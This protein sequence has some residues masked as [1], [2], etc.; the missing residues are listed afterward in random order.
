MTASTPRQPLLDVDHARVVFPQGGPHG[1]VVAVDDVSLTL[2]TGR[3]M[4]LVGASGCGKSS[5]AR[6]IMHLIPL[7]SGTI[8]IMGEDLSRL[9]RD[10]RRRKRRHFQMV[11]QDPGGS[12]DARM[13]AIDL[14]SEPLQVHGLASGPDLRD[15]ARAVLASVDI[16]ADAVDRFPHQFS[17]G[18]RQRIAIARAVVTEPSLLVCDEPTSALDVS[19]QAQVLDVLRNIQQD[20][21]LGMLFITHDMGVVRQMCDDVL[22]MDAGR[23]VEAGPVDTV[24]DAP[25]HPVTRSLL[26]ASMGT[27][28]M[29]VDG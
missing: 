5:L 15:R 2:D 20:R 17:G 4:G 9:G 3:T 27:H 23:V 26:A 7:A 19:V 24:L 11:F 12:L 10:A 29:G 22:V 14:V 21:D 28:A 16:P 18:Q 8:R 25:A 6:A 13:R 1:E